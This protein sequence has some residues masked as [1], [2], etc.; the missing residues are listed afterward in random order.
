L[1]IVAAPT[2]FS[3]IVLELEIRL[4]SKFVEKEFISYP[5]PPSSSKSSFEF[6]KAIKSEV[7][8]F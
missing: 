2:S 8:E 5:I 3:F 7:F 4:S 1:V 6:I